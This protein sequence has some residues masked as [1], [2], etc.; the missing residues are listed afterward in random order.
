MNKTKIKKISKEPGE[1]IQPI[2]KTDPSPAGSKF[3]TLPQ[4]IFFNSSG[5][6]KKVSNTGIW[7][8]KEGNPIYEI[9]RKGDSLYKIDRF[10]IFPSGGP[11]FIEGPHKNFEGHHSNLLPDWY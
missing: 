2:L 4:E 1:L 3:I 5:L 7:I 10:I 6:N 9:A 11:L 8:F